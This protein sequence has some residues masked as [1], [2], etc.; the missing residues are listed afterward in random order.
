MRTYFSVTVLSLLSLVFG[1]VLVAQQP[2][3]VDSSVTVYYDDEEIKAPQLLPV[4]FSP[5]LSNDCKNEA[6][7]IVSLSLVVDSSGRPK[8][9]APRDSFDDDLDHMA[10]AIATNDRFTPG[11]KDSN[12][13]AVAQNLEISLSICTAK[14]IGHNGKSSD[15]VRLKA[16]PVQHLFAADKHPPENIALSS[17]PRFESPSHASALRVGGS[18]SAPVPIETPEPQLTKEERKSKF[19]GICLVSIIIDKYGVPQHPRV[20]RGI[21]QDLDQKALEA[22]SRYR[23]KPAMKDKQPVPVMMTIE[24]NFRLY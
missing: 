10:I 23:F 9:V 3:T 15:R 20:I 24:V 8:N 14:V 5:L 7:G 22:V 6:D 4:D 18:V 17:K 21:N 16:L 11:A 2:V 12:P 1:I 13:V 19:S